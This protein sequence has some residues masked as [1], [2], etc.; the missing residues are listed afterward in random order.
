VRQMLAQAP[1][2]TALTVHRLL[3]QNG[4]QVMAEMR[5]QAPVAVT[6]D[7]RR[8]IHYYFL[9]TATVAVEPTADYAEY[10]EKGTSPHWVSVKPGTPL[11]RWATQK[12]IS[13]YALQRSIARKGTKPHPFIQPTY[14]IMEP[15]VHRDFNQGIDQLIARLNA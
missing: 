13:P 3:E 14:E 8:T 6:G 11:Y 15:R 4:I 7:L 5:R 2:E 12:A 9:E 10:V 1:E